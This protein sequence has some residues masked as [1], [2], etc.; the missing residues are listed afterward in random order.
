MSA[1]VIPFT[2]QWK[3]HKEP[4]RRRADLAENRA[5]F[6]A[7]QIKEAKQENDDWTAR[8]LL[9]LL[10]TLDRKQLNLLEFRLLGHLNSKSAVQALAIVQTITSDIAHRRRVKAALGEDDE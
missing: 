7:R 4:T 8:L 1:A 9:A 6:D 10:D 3:G 5:L 2:G